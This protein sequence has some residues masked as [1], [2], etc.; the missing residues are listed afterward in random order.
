M[1][2]RYALPAHFDVT[3]QDPKH[4]LMWKL[5]GVF[6]AQGVCYASERGCR[7]MGRGGSQVLTLGTDGIFGLGWICKR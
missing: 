4:G 1:S 2:T 3:L 7:R 6:W 5:M